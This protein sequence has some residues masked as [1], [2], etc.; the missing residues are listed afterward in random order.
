M[1]FLKG[2]LKFVGWDTFEYVKFQTLS[3]ISIVDNKVRLEICG[4]IVYYRLFLVEMLVSWR[5]IE[6]AR[7]T[8]KGCGMVVRT[9]LLRNVEQMFGFDDQF[10]LHLKME[11][12]QNTGMVKE[13]EGRGD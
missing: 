11:N 1:P 5:D 7:E 3:K 12:M 2:N 9:P 13:L 8:I 6:Q 10:K 4:S